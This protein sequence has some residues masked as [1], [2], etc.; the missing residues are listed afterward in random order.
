[1]WQSRACASPSTRRGL[2]HWARW[3][4]TTDGRGGPVTLGSHIPVEMFEVRKRHGSR[5][6][7][8]YIGA[9]RRCLNA[10]LAERKQMEATSCSSG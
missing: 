1:M 3:R 8:F 9:F 5:A 7:L 2:A 10:F 4:S 6:R